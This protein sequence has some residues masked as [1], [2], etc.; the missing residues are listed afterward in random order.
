MPIDLLCNCGHNVAAFAHPVKI[1]G[2]IFFLD[3]TTNRVKEVER[4]AQKPF[5]VCFLPSK[6]AIQI[7]EIQIVSF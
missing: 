5:R 6:F 1:T 2:T 3:I 4:V 7:K